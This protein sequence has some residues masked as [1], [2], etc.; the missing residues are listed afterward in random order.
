MQLL[1]LFFSALLFEWIV[2][3]SRSRLAASATLTLSTHQATV[4]SP[5][6]ARPHHALFFALSGVARF[7]LFELAVIQIGVESA[8]RQQ[9]RM[10]A[11][12]HDVAVV[13]H[14]D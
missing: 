13:H 9:V 11:L 2:N 5:C 14:Q 12:L 3:L 6:G 4:C 8:A 1:R 10:G 7:D